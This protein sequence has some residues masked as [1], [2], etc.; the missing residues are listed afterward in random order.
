MYLT[1]LV[2]AFWLV[3]PLHRYTEV[4]DD[5]TQPDSAP[6]R[7]FWEDDAT[8]KHTLTPDMALELANAAGE[9]AD[10]ETQKAYLQYADRSSR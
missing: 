4:D 1:S 3:S 9:R 2:E 10:H 5:P 7:Y 8:E 6:A